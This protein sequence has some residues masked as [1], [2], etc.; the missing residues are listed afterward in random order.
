[1][2]GVA[3][4]AAVAAM[5]MPR[6]GDGTI[7]PRELARLLI[8]H[9]IREA[10]STMAEAAAEDAGTSGNGCRGRMPNTCVGTL[11]LRIPKLGAGSF[12]PEDVMERHGRTDRAMAAATIEVCADGI[13]TRKAAGIAEALGVHGLSKDQASR[14]CRGLGAAAGDLNGRTFDVMEELPRLWLDA[15]CMKCRNEA[16]VASAAVATAIACDGN[17]SRCVVGFDVVD[18]EGH[19]SWLGFP[20]HLR[21]RGIKGTELVV[22]DAHRGS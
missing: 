20:Q 10:T 22:P 21:G 16:H 7:S 19:G 9:V 2:D 18:A 17:G 1:M 3:V 5:E 8:E 6:L 13:S 12:S 11:D 4:D 14:I 15:T